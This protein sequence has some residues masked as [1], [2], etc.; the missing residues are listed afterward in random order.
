MSTIFQTSFSEDDDNARRNIRQ[1]P[2]A[3][4]LAGQ[5]MV[6]TFNLSGKVVQALCDY[7]ATLKS[8]KNDEHIT[9]IFEN[10]NNDQDQINVFSYKD[11]AEC[12]SNEK[13]QQSAVSYLM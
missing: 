12:T 2:E 3:R 6:F 11:V 13:L 9:L 4:Y 8:L 5:G 1:G 10:F 7:G